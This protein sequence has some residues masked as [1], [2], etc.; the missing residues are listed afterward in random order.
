MVGSPSTLWNS[1]FYKYLGRS[2]T[3]T[4]FCLYIILVSSYHMVCYSFSLGCGFLGTNI[5][6]GQV[7][8]LVHIWM[9]SYKQD[10]H[11]GKNMSSVWSFHTKL[12]WIISDK[13]SLK[14]GCLISVNESAATIFSNMLSVM[15][16]F[17]RVGAPLKYQLT[18]PKTIFCC[19]L[20]DRWWISI[21]LL[22]KGNIQRI[23]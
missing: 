21:I 14:D 3:S 10:T 15:K 5:H 19:S 22:T 9:D 16:I 4:Y 18:S 20:G 8:L 13:F 23:M 7:N 1:W 6:P 12:I 2:V 17:N 11:E